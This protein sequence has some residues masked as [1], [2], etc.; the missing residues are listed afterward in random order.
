MRPEFLLEADETEKTLPSENITTIQRKVVSLAVFFLLMFQTVF[1]LSDA[2]I[3]VLFHFLSLY[4][5][6]LSKVLHCTTLQAVH[7]LFPTNVSD[8]RC[9]IGSNRDKF[10][11]F[12][13]CRLCHSIYPIADCVIDGLGGIKESRKCTIS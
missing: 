10:Q 2:A 12:A 13:C 6:M 1:R 11:K 4:F 3:N 9:L 8:G 5:K 7:T